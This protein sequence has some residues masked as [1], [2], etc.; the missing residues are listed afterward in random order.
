[1]SASIHL[2]YGT[3]GN[4]VTFGFGENQDASL[5]NFIITNGH[6]SGRWPENQ[7]GGI[8]MYNG[9]SPTLRNLNIINNFANSHG[10]GISVQDDCAP[11]ISFCTIKNNTANNEG[12]GAFFFNN[13]HATLSNINILNNIAS[14]GGSAR[15]S[16]FWRVFKWVFD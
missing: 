2:N 7:G 11:L 3:I 1:M 4:V 6:A 14:R 8:V 10:G 13:S 16:H 15:Y 5:E 12:G 9:S